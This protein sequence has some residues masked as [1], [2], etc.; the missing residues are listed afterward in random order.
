MAEH[1]EIKMKGS[2]AA[3]FEEADPFR[4]TAEPS[5]APSSVPTSAPSGVP[6]SLPSGE[7]S[8]TPTTSFPPTNYPTAKPTNE[9]TIRPTFSVA[10]IPS[11]P[12]SGYFNY[13]ND[14]NSDEYGPS[15]WKNINAIQEEDPGYFWHTFDLEERVTNDCSSGKKQ[16]PINVC[17]KPKESCT[18]THEMRPKVS[19]FLRILFARD[20]D[21]V[22][23]HEFVHQLSFS[24][25]SPKYISSI[26]SLQ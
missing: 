17:Q 21:L 24:F 22:P 5:S 14:S 18:E 3:L 4:F 12:K 10:T 6:S 16:S 20:Y 26:C 1:I 25:L 13:D 15:K 9:P 2:D 23:L 11:N 19:Y 7:P 8:D